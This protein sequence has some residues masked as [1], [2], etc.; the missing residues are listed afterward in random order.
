M[1]G[2]NQNQINEFQNILNAASL[3]IGLQNLQ[4]N[5]EQ[6]RQNDVNAANDR[7]ANYLLEKINE[8]LKK[9]TD[10][11]NDGIMELGRKIEYLKIDIEYT[12]SVLDILINKILDKVSTE[13]DNEYK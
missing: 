2:L 11:L 10:S 7:Q 8:A 12:Q 6:S 13:K 4:E 9:Q 3:L 1:Y 5:R